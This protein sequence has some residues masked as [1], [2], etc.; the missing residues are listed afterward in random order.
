MRLSV[1]S[2]FHINKQTQ[3]WLDQA[4]VARHERKDM[5]EITK[6]KTI[7]TNPSGK[8]SAATDDRRVESSLDRSSRQL[9]EQWFKGQ[10]FKLVQIGD[11]LIVIP[12]A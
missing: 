7:K 9:I 5:E 10:P 4:G 1:K 8:A 6:P 11:R 12:A 3:N 2:S